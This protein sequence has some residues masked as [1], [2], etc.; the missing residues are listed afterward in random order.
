MTAGGASQRLAILDCSFERRWCG[1][2]HDGWCGAIHDGW[3][4]R[5]SGSQY[6]TSL[7]SAAGNGYCSQ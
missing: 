3:W 5:A 7:L 6:W 4:V 2:M 1:A